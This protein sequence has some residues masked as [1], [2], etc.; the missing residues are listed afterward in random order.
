MFQNY[1]FNH[2]RFSHSI[3]PDTPGILVEMGYISN[4]ADLAFLQQADKPAFAIYS[5]VMNFLK[6]QGR[7]LH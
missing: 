4:E 7:I 1:A 5:G 6:E 2:Q 3:D